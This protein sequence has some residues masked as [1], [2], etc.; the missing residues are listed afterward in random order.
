MS[1]EPNPEG[2]EDLRDARIASMLTIGVPREGDTRRK[3]TPESKDEAVDL[4]EQEGTV[5][6][7]QLTEE[8]P[9]GV[10]SGEAAGVRETQDPANQPGGKQVDQGTLGPNTMAQ[11]K[12]HGQRQV[13]RI[14]RLFWHQSI[15]YALWEVGAPGCVTTYMLTLLLVVALI[16]IL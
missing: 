7:R 9:S 11:E 1:G 8:A 15:E 2:E 13:P 14:L 12:G 5:G 3:T 4:L 16:P 6:E 10:T